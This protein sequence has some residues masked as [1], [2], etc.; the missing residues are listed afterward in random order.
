[1][2]AVLRFDESKHQ[3]NPKRVKV[4]GAQAQSLAKSSKSAV[5]LHRELSARG[6]KMFE[7]SRGRV[8]DAHAI[9]SLQYREREKQKLSSDIF[10]SLFYLQNSPKY[11]NIIHTIGYSPFHVMYGSPNQ[12]RLLY[13]KRNKMTKL[14]CD[15]TGSVVRKISKYY[16]VNHKSLLVAFCLHTNS[17]ILNHH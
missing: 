15:A 1:M 2:F 7:A 8:P 11:A 10:K 17:K 12:F 5:V 16:L 6:G 9:R 14:S 4:T 13:L 3:H